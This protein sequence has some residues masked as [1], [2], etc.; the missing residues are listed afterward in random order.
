MI[1]QFKKEASD[2]TTWQ[3]IWWTEYSFQL[4]TEHII[5]IGNAGKQMSKLNTHMAVFYIHSDVAVTRN[6][7]GQYKRTRL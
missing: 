3:N 6:D 7:T 1:T 4:V 2:T 5:S